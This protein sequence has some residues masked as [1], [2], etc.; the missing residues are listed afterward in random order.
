MSQSVAI[1]SGASRRI[2]HDCKT[3]LARDFSAIMVAARSSEMLQDTASKL[4]AGGAEPLA[5]A[6]DLREPASAEAVVK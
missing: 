6:L 2:G 3:R 1:V 5:L 4:Q